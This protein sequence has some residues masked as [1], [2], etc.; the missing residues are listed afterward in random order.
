MSDKE[1]DDMSSEE[2]VAAEKRENK[3]IRRSS[4]RLRTA[5]LDK[6]AKDIDTPEY[7]NLDGSSKQTYAIVTVLD[8][9]DR[10][11]QESEKTLAAKEG[12]SDMGSLVTQV[13][14]GLVGR[15]GDPSAK[16]A[17]GE[18]GTRDIGTN[19]RLRPD[20][21]ASAQHMHTGKDEIEFD[22]VFV[23]EKDK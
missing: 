4:R 14:E 7:P 2:Q 11:V 10:D 21:T 9:L 13:F 6:I 20:A 8:G 19:Q 18:R 1:W 22:E 16:F 23:Q 12:A 3:Q 17:S 15:I 5:M